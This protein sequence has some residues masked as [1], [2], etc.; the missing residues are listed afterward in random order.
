MAA[1]GVLPTY[2]RYVNGVPVPSSRKTLRLREKY[3]I[4]LV[5]ATFGI[6]CFGA[7]F[8]LPN[9]QDRVTMV[10]VRKRFRDAGEGLFLPQQE[11]GGGPGKIIRHDDI[12]DPH[13]IDD[14]I[15]L[16]MNIEKDI[17]N[18]KEELK[19][20]G[21]KDEEAE[22]I[23]DEIKEDKEKVIQQKKE[24]EEVKKEEDKKKALEVDKDHVGHP[25][26][27]GGEPSEAS[28]KEKRDK[29]REMMNHAWSNYV[30][31][32]WGSNELRPISKRGHSA[33]IFG[34]LSLGATI[35]DALDTLYIM[36]MEDEYKAARDW[37]ATNLNFDG[38]SEL[39]V[40]ETN[41]RFIGGLLA[42]YALTGDQMFKKKSQMIADKLMPAFNTPT[43]IP[44]S[45]VNIKTG[46]TRNWGW[47]S[48]GC[49]IL[50]EFGSLHLEFYYLSAITG[51]SK[52]LEKAQKVRSVLQQLEKP[53]GLYPNYL[54]PKTGKWGQHHVS[55]G[56]LGDSFYEY[57]LKAYLLSGKEDKEAKA[58][59]DATI[60]AMLDKM[61]QT[62]KSGMKY[63]GEYK[64]G[65]IEHKMD[66]LSCFSGG[67]LALGAKDM[68]DEAKYLQLGADIAHTCHQSYDRTAVKLGPEAF[69]FDGS[70]EA[71]A[72]RSNEKYYILRPE[73]M[74]TYFYMWRLTKDQKYRDW[75]W[76][77]AQALEKHC[78][79]DG[80]FTGLRD[81][82]QASPQK[83]DVQQSFLLAETLKYL[84]LTFSDDS[85]IPLNKWVF[86]TE[87]HP[88]PV[89]D[90]SVADA[91]AAA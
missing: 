66:H 41:I 35:V 77:A 53:N 8:F 3:I 21:I 54:N 79:V 39:S 26:A 33:S 25:G 84:Y 42:A 6:V 69:R 28:V 90:T 65:R 38:P 61:L 88:F 12:V 76:E 14:K 72:T 34:S 40:F 64:S 20:Q 4:L 60:K 55:M 87:A 58:M 11:G 16:Q 18:V 48:G 51:D 70:S 1:S 13:K 73:V 50:S 17:I 10:E 44:Y 5:F 2:Q 47:A 63:F 7:F 22:K 85:L 82:Y 32:A 74:E 86:N 27:Q 31:Y 71:V 23:K 29:I 91:A 43:G 81:V 46:S 45:M 78:R 75:A 59:Y 83:D 62:S 67:M 89:K 80:G 15:R 49:S 19:K 56:A 52:Y 57:L 24:A 9:L 37:I 36:E 68:E 30:K